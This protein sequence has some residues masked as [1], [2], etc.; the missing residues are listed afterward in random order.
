MHHAEVVDVD[1]K[2]QLLLVRQ[3]AGIDERKL[4]HQAS[5]RSKTI[6]QTPLFGPEA[7]PGRRTDK[8]GA[9]LTAQVSSP[10]V[11]D[12]HEAQ[13]DAGDVDG[14]PRELDEPPLAPGPGG[15]SLLLRAAV[16]AALGRRRS[17]VLERA[18][19]RRG[20][21]HGHGD[22]GDE[23]PGAD[24]RGDELGR[25]RAAQLQLRRVRRRRLVELVED[26]H[27][28]PDELLRELVR[29]A[30]HQARRLALGRRRV[31]IL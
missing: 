30:A 10:Q 22:L 25:R 15:R 17:A 16:A 11:L 5:V 8:L 3:E 14:G 1:P 2:R 20:A 24:A 12:V 18:H 6:K 27:R 29:A 9:Q 7:S 19:R 31:R 26:G 23:A 21:I 13:R 28:Q 4:L